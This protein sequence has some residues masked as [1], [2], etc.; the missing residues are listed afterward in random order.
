M[1]GGFLIAAVAKALA[2]RDAWIGWTPA[3]RRQFR[4]RLVG[5]SQLLALPSVGIPLLASHALALVTRRLG[6][7]WLRRYGYE[8]LACETFTTPPWRGT[9]GL[10]ANWL[11]GPPAAGV[12]RTAS[13]GAPRR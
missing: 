2:A 1:L 6:R 9:C 5:N 10:A 7:D 11:W 8:P 3:Q 4:H 13:I 12:G